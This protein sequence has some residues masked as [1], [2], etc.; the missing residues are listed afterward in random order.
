[1]RRPSLRVVLAAILA[2]AGGGALAQAAWIPAKAALAQVLIERAWVRAAAGEPEARPWPW[3]DTEPVA[4]L[5]AP[6][7]GERLMVLSGFGGHTLAFG[8]G[9]LPGSP[10]PGES[11][12]SVL[13]GH[14]DTHFAFL[15]TVAV[16]D[17]LAVERP[18]GT[19]Q[20]YRVTATEVTDEADTGP[21][22][23]IEG[24]KV[25]TL[26]TCYPFHAV[27]PGG[28]LRY[29]VRAEGVPP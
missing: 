6:A 21:L 13:A 25:L 18:D 27:V 8:P 23:P 4:R 28:P 20:R 11:G 16:G 29:V 15:E 5:S 12:N 10:L 2:A 7:Q 9:H 24:R 22:A 14:R 3:A 1:M 17:L 19:R 26:I